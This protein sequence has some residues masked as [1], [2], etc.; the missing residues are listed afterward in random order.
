MRDKSENEGLK[1]L[2]IMPLESPIYRIF[3]NGRRT[4]RSASGKKLPHLTSEL[5]ELLLIKTNALHYANEQLNFDVAGIMKSVIL[6][7]EYLIEEART[8][9]QRDIG[10]IHIDKLQGDGC[11]HH[12]ERVAGACLK[13]PEKNGRGNRLI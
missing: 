9:V 4:Y 6:D 2:G 13:E 7:L 12:R 5:F 1:I 10:E 8:I 3:E 11:F